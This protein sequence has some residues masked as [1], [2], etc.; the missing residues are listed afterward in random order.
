MSLAVGGFD[1]PRLFVDGARN[2]TYLVDRFKL[3]VTC[4]YPK[5]RVHGTW[6]LALYEL[7]VREPHADRYAV[8][9][10]D[11]VCPRGLR[12]YLDSH[13][14][15]ADAYW[16]LYTCRGNTD[17]GRTYLDTGL[18][19]PGEPYPGVPRGSVPGWYPSNQR[20]WGAL[21]L[22]F[23]RPAV[24]QLLSSD[25]MLS[26]PMNPIRGWRSVDGG[27]VDSMRKVGRK[28]LVHSPSLLQ[29]TG[30]VSAMDKSSPSLGLGDD[31][32]RQEWRPGH[33][34]AE[35]SDWRGEDFDVT[36]LLK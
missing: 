28:E 2:F 18:V 3:D 17:P 10:D 21:G 19:R 5:L 9:Q 34:L 16:N 6:V 7:Y 15:P 29:H 31:Y 23:D 20:G 30:Q 25:H 4:H 12:A 27:V 26:R 33:Y 35:A 24:L 13:P 22:V 14:F 36:D 1:R 8:F 32:P 11:L